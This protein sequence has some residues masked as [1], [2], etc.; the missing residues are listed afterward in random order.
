MPIFAPNINKKEDYETKDT[1]LDG[2]MPVRFDRPAHLHVLRP[3][4]LGR[5]LFTHQTETMDIRC[6]AGIVPLLSRPS[7]RRRI[8]FFPDPTR[9]SERR[10]FG[11]GPQERGAL[12]ARGLRRRHCRLEPRP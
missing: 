7:R 11:T 9:I 12:L 4:P 2:G 6:D 8:G 3:G 1:T 10:R 5:I